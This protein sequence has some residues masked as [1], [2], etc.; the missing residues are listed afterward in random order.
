MKAKVLELFED[1]SNDRKQYAEGDV[2]ETD[3]VQRLHDLSTKNNKRNLVIVEPN[4]STFK[5]AELQEYAT[6]ENVEI[7][8]KDT[9]AELT[10]KLEGAE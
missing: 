4:F 5:K 9:V 10:E 2:F 1:L 3:N 7:E 8:D 6:L